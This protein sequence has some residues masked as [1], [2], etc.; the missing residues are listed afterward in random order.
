MSENKKVLIISPFFYPAIGGAETQAMALA[1]GL[2]SRNF[3][4]AV[5]TMKYKTSLASSEQ[6]TGGIK[7]IRRST[8]LFGLIKLLF[9]TRPALIIWNGFFSRKS[10][11]SRFQQAVLI[12]IS[13]FVCKK[14]LFR[15]PS[16]EALLTEPIT[17]WFLSK[18]VTKFIPLT[19]SQQEYLV[20]AGFPSAKMIPAPNT[21]IKS[22]P[23]RKN[24]PAKQIK[25]VYCGRLIK[26]K[27]VD[28]LINAIGKLQGVADFKVQL[29]FSLSLESPEESR[30][31]LSLVSQRQL[32]L[33][34]IFEETN[35]SK[36]F[37]AANIGV[38]SSLSE[39]APNV[40]REMMAEGL[41]VVA[42]NIPGCMEIIS[43]FKDGLIFEAGNSDIL[44]EKLMLLI[45][46]PQLIT[47]LGQNAQRK[48]REIANESKIVSKLLN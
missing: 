3:S 48:I 29:L 44:A 40:L 4:V 20:N 27:G 21:I 26:R 2:K 12:S 17:G 36:Y 39:G 25:I 6:M 9:K 35:V 43:D 46:N 41:A 32:P 42:S 13:S 18:F 8:L 7:I 33:E 10:K 1:N 37:R 14:V 22:G 30:D 24:I 47:K 15:I 16:S 5:L 34:L 38:F 11:F 28:T 19:Y 23:S 45:N 31:L